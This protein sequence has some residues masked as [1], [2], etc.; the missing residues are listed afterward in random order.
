M[1]VAALRLLILTGARRNEVLRL[2]WEH[3]DREHGIARLED[4]KTGQRALRLSAPAWEV[5]DDLRGDVHPIKGWC[6][7]SYRTAGAPVTDV[8]GTFRAVCSIA[9]LDKLRLHD[10][11]H[12]HASVAAGQG[13]SLPLIGKL[14]GH[15]RATT[16]E[17]Y[18]H[19][20]DDPVRDAADRV[21]G[22][23]A[24]RLAKPPA[25]VEPLRQGSRRHRGGSHS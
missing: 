7:P 5:L 2:R 11:R 12:S 6:F 17:R 10:L 20:A 8:R 22:R 16:T 21:Q 24:D 18:A 25:K 14:L 23:L 3:L 4:T 9:G 15:K 1:A 13:L 19:F